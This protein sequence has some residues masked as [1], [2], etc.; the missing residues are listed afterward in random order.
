[1][2]DYDQ[3][4]GNPHS[5]EFEKWWKVAEEYVQN[6]RF[7]LAKYALERALPHASNEKMMEWS[8][9]G[10]VATIYKGSEDY[11]TT[12]TYFD[13][14]ILY[15]PQ[16]VQART[17]FFK[18]QALE[19]ICI[20]ENER[21][22]A[23]KV[24]E[25]M[26]MTWDTLST[27]SSIAEKQ[28]DRQ[29]HTEIEG[30]LARFEC[31]FSIY[32]ADYLAQS[33]KRAREVLAVDPSNRDAKCALDDAVIFEALVKT[34]QKQERPAEGDAA[35][36]MRLTGIARIIVMFL[37]LGS[38]VI[39]LISSEYYNSM[40]LNWGYLIS[41]AILLV[42]AIRKGKVDSASMAVAVTVLTSLGLVG[43]YYSPASQGVKMLIERLI[44]DFSSYPIEY[45]IAR[46]AD[47][48]IAVIYWLLTL[49]RTKTPKRPI[50]ILL[51]LFGIPV[52]LKLTWVLR[53]F[54]GGDSF[55][56]VIIRAAN[57]WV[58]C[59]IYAAF[60]IA[61]LFS[62]KHLLGKSGKKAVKR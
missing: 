4:G 7:D 24:Q 42:V 34:N 57:Y 37:A 59:A 9:L 5:A 52:L 38:I 3:H 22:N 54:G 61:I 49:K 17:Y 41:S 40:Q 21:N 51:S 10:Q 45:H 2:T 1:M 26:P 15:A 27:T 23:D 53:Y 16:N 20:R 28:G 31:H 60:F 48:L 55:R 30:H 32:N 50:C 12:I 46:L 35:S 18:A 39:S 44:Q 11:E 8:F 56:R 13:K 6:D 43:R 62:G 14:T 47:V 19:L 58:P 29:L 36:A 25:Y 33:E